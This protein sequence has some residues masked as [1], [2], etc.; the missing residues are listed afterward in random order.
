[1]RFFLHGVIFAL[2][3]SSVLISQT[4]NPTA[5]PLS[6]DE[7]DVVKISSTLIQIDVTVTDKKGN[8][9]SDLTADEFEVF[10]NGKKQDISNFSFVSSRNALTR[11]SEKNIESAGNIPVPQVTKTLRNQARRTIV[12]VVDDL[13]LS[14]T[15]IKAVRRG[16]RNYLDNQMLPG[17]LVAIIKTSGGSGVFQQF[18]S[19]KN[20]LDAA[21]K[22]V[23]WN[24]NGI[25]GLSAFERIS[26]SDDAAAPDDVGPDQGNESVIPRIFRALK[27]IIRGMK[28]L[29]GRKSLVLIS[30]G[31]SLTVDPAL[32]LETNIRNESDS[33]TSRDFGIAKELVKLA[34]RSSVVIYSVDARG[35]VD[36]G[37]TAAD[38]TSIRSPGKSPI[39]S[40]NF[41]RFTAGRRRKLADTRA[42]MKF[43]A[44]ETGGFAVANNN[45]IGQGIE[46]IVDDQ[47]YYLVGY[48]PDEE[49][50]DPNIRRFNKFE[51]KVRR[52]GLKVRYRSGFF[53]ESDEI[54]D[55]TEAA[56]SESKIVKAIRSPFDINGIRIR[57]NP[58]FSIDSQNRMFLR[59]FLHINAEDLTFKNLPDGKKTASVE[60]LSGNFNSL[61]NIAD[62]FS[63]IHSIAIG[64]VQFET[65]RRE[66]LIYYFEF[67]IKDGGAYQMRIAIRDTVTDKT[68]TASQFINIPKVS[69]KRLMLSGIVLENLSLEQWEKADRDSS[70]GTTPLMDNAL[71][72]FKRESVLNY[73]FDIYNSANK[74]STSKALTFRT[75][76][77]FEGDRIHEG[78]DSP[79]EALQQG[80]N[81]V[82]AAGGIN[83]HS[84][85]KP[86]SYVLQII[87]T[88]KLA[89]KKQQIATQFVQFEIVE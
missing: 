68:G 62:Q 31:F 1:M 16:L 70:T 28:E 41:D 17:D 5:T 36:T 35:V 39:I 38:N 73:G 89:K 34:N 26:V 54:G 12:L 45:D 65:V 72:Q 55:E 40:R 66:G 30:E 46:K 24:P 15:S 64:P 50:F 67:P 4:P 20:I 74:E 60:V 33:T 6:D 57:I 48:Q 18:T 51:I 42:G 7:S 3:F 32:E 11:E 22:E 25:G 37:F 85:L 59:T 19:N 87:V 79:I 10:E 47:S 78:K 49:V 52:K 44:E 76:L 14:S 56:T 84:D 80:N 27:D 88:D 86:G 71:R 29:P 21:I 82:T 2:L 58:L 75:R 83:L 63:K 77:Y 9:V 69:E 8:I 53:G 23:R 13:T 81:I 61:G 43:I